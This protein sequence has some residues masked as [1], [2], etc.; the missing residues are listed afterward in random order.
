[1][2]SLLEVG[3]GFHPELTGRE[4]I[5]L[6]GS[7]LGMSHA[8]IL[9]S[10][11]EIVAFSEIEQF[12]DTPVKRYSSGMYVR[13]AFAVAAHLNPEILVVDEVLAVGDY[14]FQKKCVG[15]MHD[16]AR[17]GRT[18]LFVSHNMPVIA[19][20]CERVVMLRGGCV[21]MDGP[22]DHVVQEYFNHHQCDQDGKLDLALST[23]MPN[24]NRRAR[25]VGCTLHSPLQVGPWSL[26]FG[27]D[28]SLQ[29]AISVLE[30]IRFFEF[31]IALCTATGSEFAS[32]VSSDSFPV[33]SL[34]P[35]DYVM[36]MALPDFTLAPGRY[37][38][39]FGMRSDRGMEDYITEAA[40]LE[41][42]PNSAAGRM[43]TNQR[44]G[45]VIPKV[46]F[47]IQKTQNSGLVTSSLT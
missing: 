38:L 18:V 15:R 40:S 33:G 41:V 43:R 16:V 11:H 8:E 25:F 39:D 3:T 10:F 44:R 13:L 26:P 30:A 7:I 45:A 32:P 24:T 37:M 23:R 22:A 28:V 29:L 21:S 35:G 27:S 46:R 19:E 47:E 20:L 34:E 31:G 42:L 4:N 6:N 2:S 36:T 14:A 9:R 1:M 17:E 5:F 12:L